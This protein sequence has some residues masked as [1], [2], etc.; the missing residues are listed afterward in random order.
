MRLRPDHIQ[1][2]SELIVKNLKSHHLLELKVPEANVLD[3]TVAVI[4]K[5]M[6]AEEQI[7]L[8]AKKM[9]E[10]FRS[11]IESGD[12]DERKVFQMIKKQIAKDKK[13]VL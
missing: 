3:K 7:D 12:M 2:I 11:Q 10:K 1:K 9:M 6:E 8:E 4:T 5:N 13:F